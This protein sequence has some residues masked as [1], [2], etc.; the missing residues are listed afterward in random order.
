MSACLVANG[1][2]DPALTTQGGK[3]RSTHVPGEPLS[4]AAAR[5]VISH[6][7]LRIGRPSERTQHGTMATGADAESSVAASSASVSAS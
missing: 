1:L 2:R 5:V 4:D 7:L 3:R 6:C